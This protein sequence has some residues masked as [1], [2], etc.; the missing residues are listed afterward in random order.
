M[1]MGLFQQMHQKTQAHI[2]LV[3]PS[4][5]LELRAEKLRHQAFSDFGSKKKN[6]RLENNRNLETLRGATEPF[7]PDLPL[8]PQPLRTP[9]P[10]PDPDLT[11]LT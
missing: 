10:S 8:R 6:N 3:Q 7:Q 9:P 5:A 11:F 1:G 2:K 4:L